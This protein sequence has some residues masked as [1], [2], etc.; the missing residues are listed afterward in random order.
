MTTRARHRPHPP[1]PGPRELPGIL[2]G[3]ARNPLSLIT[4]LRDR[5]GTVAHLNVAGRHVYLVSDPDIVHRVLVGEAGATEKWRLAGQCRVLFGEGL[6][7]SGGQLHRDQ[8]RLMQPAFRHRRLTGYTG[9]VTRRATAVADA[10][11]DG[12][13]VDTSAEMTG[14]TTLVVGEALFGTRLDDRLDEIRAALADVMEHFVRIQPPFGPML[15]GLPTPGVRAFR[16]SRRRLDAFVAELVAARRAAAEPGDDLLALLLAGHDGR[17]LPDDLIRDEV[18][19]MLGAGLETTANALSFAWWALAHHP[20]AEARLHEEIDAW[21]GTPD[22]GL[23]PVTRAVVDETLRLFPPAWMLA[24]RTTA[25][26]PVGAW[27]AP[28]GSLLLMPPWLMHRDPAHWSAPERFDIGRWLGGA[29]PPRAYLPFGAGTRKCIGTAFARMEAT[30]ALA[31]IARRWRLRPLPGHPMRL[32]AMVTLRPAS[33]PL[34][35]VE[36]RSSP[37]PRS[38][39]V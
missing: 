22:A 9:I 30:L 18:L 7:T 31:V 32:R 20:G 14:L 17:G 1:G 15:G 33:G 11:R 29:P 39:A 21:D 10:W 25:A 3:R 16:A 19:T 12:A 26:I 35:R 4:R 13:H 28:A 36:R 2:T 38:A 6:L 27:V 24:R 34:M 5:H 8:R 23:L 37:A